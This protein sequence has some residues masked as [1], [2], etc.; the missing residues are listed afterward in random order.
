MQNRTEAYVAVA[1]IFI[2]I[3]LLIANVTETPIWPYL[4]PT[5]LILIGVWLVARPR[6]TSNL[7]SQTWRILDGVHRTGRWQVT[8]ENVWSLIGDSTIDLRDADIPPGE[9]RIHVRGIVGDV[10]VRVPPDAGVRVTAEAF[11]IDAN[12]F[13]YNQDYILT[14]YETQTP[15]YDEVERRVHIDLQFFVVD[16]HLT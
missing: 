16:L 1:V 13:G 3:L 2:G 9:T 10:N 12:D 11:V 14:P 4:W 6:V 5:T 7:G 15:N 8:N